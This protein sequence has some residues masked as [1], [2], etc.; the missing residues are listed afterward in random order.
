M[1]TTVRV[2]D[3]KSGLVH[4]LYREDGV[5]GLRS[6]GDEHDTSGAFIILTDAEA[7]R[8]ESDSLCRKCWPAG[9]P[10]EVIG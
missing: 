3:V 5:R 1:T 10:I 4:K 2:Q 9:I 6:S 8:V 7:E